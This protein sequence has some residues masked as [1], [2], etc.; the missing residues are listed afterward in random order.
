MLDRYCIGLQ[1]LKLVKIYFDSNVVEQCH[2]LFSNLYGIVIDNCIYDENTF[3]T[4]LSHCSSLKELE[5]SRFKYI[6]GFGVNIDG[7]GLA[8]DIKTLESITISTCSCF[9]YIYIREFFVKNSQLKKLKIFGSFFYN[10]LYRV[11]PRYLQLSIPN[12][13]ELS[14]C[15]VFHKIYDANEVVRLEKL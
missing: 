3:T 13:E 15:S 12:K 9:Q 11:V 7:H 10:G 1:K 4:C 14:V 2:R 5:L 8:N 6:T